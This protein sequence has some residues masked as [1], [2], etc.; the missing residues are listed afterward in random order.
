MLTSD[1]S[2]LVA[3]FGIARG[4]GGKD[5]LT[6]TGFAVGTRPTRCARVNGLSS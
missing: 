4:L 1:G 5:G 2:T 3:D 6:Q